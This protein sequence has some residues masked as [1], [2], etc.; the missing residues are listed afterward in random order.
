MITPVTDFNVAL[1]NLAARDACSAMLLFAA[2]IDDY[3]CYEYI[4][5]A[6]PT[7]TS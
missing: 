4:V 1:I 7:R 5:N 6:F 2:Y 3:L